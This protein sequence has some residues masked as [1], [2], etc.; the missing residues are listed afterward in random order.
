M[1]IACSTY[2]IYQELSEVESTLTIEN[3]TNSNYYYTLTKVNP[4]WFDYTVEKGKI[5]SD[6]KVYIPL[7][8]TEDTEFILDLKI[9]SITYSNPP[10]NIRE[11]KIA[12]PIQNEG[13]RYGD[14][15][16]V[17]KFKMRQGRGLLYYIDL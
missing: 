15:N 12:N 14:Y 9:S 17:A 2:G 11:V 3:F 7:Y 4:Y 6:K 10:K 1:I 5:G 8:L 16:A 13:Y